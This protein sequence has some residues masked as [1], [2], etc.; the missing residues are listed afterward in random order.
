MSQQNWSATPDTTITKDTLDVSAGFHMHMA[1]SRV[2]ASTPSQWRDY[3]VTGFGADGTISVSTFWE[4]SSQRADQLTLWHHLDLR[5]LVEV[6]SPVSV[7]NT[8][9]V[10]SVGGDR[11]NVRITDAAA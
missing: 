11:F 5:G 10:L 3:V 9:H 4:G 2:V 8:Y 6:G 7:H 1:L